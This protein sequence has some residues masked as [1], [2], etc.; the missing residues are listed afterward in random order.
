[1][2]MRG[3]CTVVGGLTLTGIGM[4]LVPYIRRRAPLDRDQRRALLENFRTLVGPRKKV[5]LKGISHEGL[6]VAFEDMQQPWLFAGFVEAARAVFAF[7][8]DATGVMTKAEFQSALHKMFDI[9]LTW[10]GTTED[11]F[12]QAAA[13]RKL[14]ERVSE[15]AFRVIDE[16]AD[17]AINASEFIGAVLLVLAVA[18]GAVSDA[19]LL[20]RLAF[21]VVDEDGDGFISEREL[22][23]WVERA[24]R[25]GTLPPET[26]L[27]PCGPFGLFGKRVLT[28]A[29]LTR[30]WLREADVDRDGALSPD[31]FAILELSL[32]VHEIITR[33]ARKFT[34]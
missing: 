19:S 29:K 26:W 27:E 18:N 31:E 12:E 8:A 34:V 21:R 22:L 20:Q 3:T 7:Y 11:V 1:M 9:A 5:D 15:G 23:H 14:V 33:L 17:G 2:V 32:C 24:Q 4:G 10:Y 13:V 30:K 28:P 25:H 6:Q 16:D